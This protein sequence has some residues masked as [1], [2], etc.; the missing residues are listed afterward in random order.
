MFSPCKF[1]DGNCCISF[2]ITATSFDILRI[3]EKTGLKPNEFA[4]LRRLDLL[5]FEEREIVECKEGKY[6]ESCVLA[7]KSHPCY[8]FDSAIGC[9]IHSYKP[10][11]CRI[12]PNDARGGFGK[13]AFC[14]L[15]PSII[16]R[17]SRAPKRLL[18][19]YQ[20]EKESYYELVKKCNS[21]KLNKQ[22]A[23]KFLTSSQ[24]VRFLYEKLECA[25]T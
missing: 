22:N 25:K 23:F 10:L 16:F 15:L 3:V 6:T 2:V 14:P 4:E 18:E 19:Q 24:N 20:R 13:R 11:A 8:F 5:S 12:Y 7:L 17:F 21:K 1:C 9:K